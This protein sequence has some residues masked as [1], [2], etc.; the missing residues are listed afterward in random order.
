MVLMQRWLSL[1]RTC[2]TLRPGTWW[3]LVKFTS[4]GVRYFQVNCEV[5]ALPSSFPLLCFAYLSLTLLLILFIHSR[6]LCTVNLH[7]RTHA[8][9]T[10]SRRIP[11]AVLLP[12][13]FAIYALPS[14]VKHAPTPPVHFR[15][16]TDTIPVPVPASA[17]VRSRCGLDPP[18]A[19][20]DFSRMSVRAVRP[21]VHT[22]ERLDCLCDISSGR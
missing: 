16:L 6:T 2:D 3:P 10:P 19:P 5:L 14:L 17:T 9:P 21:V 8:A 4:S 13:L 11:P 18:Y 12:S 22:S 20:P 1:D 15:A 7:A